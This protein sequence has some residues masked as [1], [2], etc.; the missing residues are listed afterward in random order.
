MIVPSIQGLL[1]T[2]AL[3]GRGAMGLPPRLL[4]EDRRVLE[5]TILPAYARRPDIQSV[6]FVGCAPYTRCYGEY[7]AGRAYW[8]ID[9]VARR[10]RY[11]SA[12]HIVDQLQYLGRHVKP[13]YFDLVICNGVLGWGL[14][15]LADADAAFAACHAHLRAGGDLLLGWNDV[16]PRNSVSPDDIPS[17]RGFERARLEEVRQGRWVVDAPHRHVFE[18]FR[19]PMQCRNN[20]NKKAKLVDL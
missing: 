2:V 7:F 16:P 12:N 20:L 11:G 10:R 14:N 18:F 5:Q 17:L 6:L 8:T 4:S 19:K 1:R 13:A 9:P 15:A 3:A